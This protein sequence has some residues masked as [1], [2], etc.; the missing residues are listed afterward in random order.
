MSKSHRKKKPNRPERVNPSS[1]PNQL[2]EQGEKFRSN[3]LYTVFTVLILLPWLNIFGNGIHAVNY[4]FLLVWGSALLGLVVVYGMIRRY[5]A[6]RYHPFLLIVALWFLIKVISTLHAGYL[7]I[8]LWQWYNG[9]WSNGM[10]FLCAQLVFGAEILLLQPRRNH[11]RYLLFGYIFQGILL[12]AGFISEGLRE[13]MLQHVVRPVTYLQNSDAAV[14]YLMFIIPLAVILLVGHWRLLT[15]WWQRV[16]AVLGMTVLLLSLFLTLPPSL[17]E[18]VYHLEHRGGTA[19][20]N[21][22]TQPPSWGGKFLADDSNVERFVQWKI[23]A[24][25]G[26]QHP[27]FG[28]GPGLERAYF[29]PVID[30]LNI[31]SWPYYNNTVMLHAHNDLLDQFATTGWPGTI[32][33]VLMWI[34]L[35]VY[36]LLGWKRI[37]AA[38]RPLILGT[39]LGLAGFTLFNFFYF[40]ISLTGIMTAVWVA[41]LLADLPQTISADT[42][43]QKVVG[44][45]WLLPFVALCIAAIPAGGLLS[46]ENKTAASDTAERT[47]NLVSA[48]QYAINAATA[49]PEGGFFQANAARLTFELAATQGKKLPPGEQEQLAR[50]SAAYGSQAA[51]LNP[52][53]PSFVF[54]KGLSRYY[55]SPAGS[56]DEQEAVAVLDQA[57]QQNGLFYLLTEQIGD[58]AAAKGDTALAKRYYSIALSN[59]S[60]EGDRPELEKKLK[61]VGGS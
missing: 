6:I 11:V 17:Q 32:L 23:A 25:M 18:A 48:T 60:P 40:T 53:N 13:G 51:Q 22:A 57:V 50:Y 20:V 46:A 2:T 58:I 12:G 54:L 55:F 33:Y 38:D 56:K 28:V 45:L 10:V 36:I 3:T 26:S 43:W 21:T 5:I 19:A 37:A 4:Y 9:G 35:P 39:L 8:S 52:F 41:V 34:L 42:W 7:H 31:M 24:T 44:H 27:L 47:G 29:F 49:F 15:R 30:D 61:S 16:L 14:S 59:I 1:V